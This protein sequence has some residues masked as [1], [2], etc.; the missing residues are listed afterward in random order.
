MENVKGADIL[1]KLLRLLAFQVGSEVS[2]VELGNSLQLNRQTV[3]R[4]LDLLS[5]FL[6]FTHFRL[7]HS[8]FSGLAGIIPEIFRLSYNS[9]WYKSK[10][11]T[12]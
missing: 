1:Y 8:R 4:Y 2:T 5:R 12:D 10:I 3:D 9:I 7:Y 6:S 11:A